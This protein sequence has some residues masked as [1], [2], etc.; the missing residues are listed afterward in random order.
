MDRF[1]RGQRENRRS[2]LPV[3]RKTNEAASRR[4]WSAFLGLLGLPTMQRQTR[5]SRRAAAGP[6]LPGRLTRFAEATLRCGYL[7]AFLPFLPAALAAA[8]RSAFL[9][10]ELRFC[11]FVRPWLCPIAG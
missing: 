5:R 10:R 6:A 2:S 7:P 3:L 1:F 11:T 8:S 4:S 9:R